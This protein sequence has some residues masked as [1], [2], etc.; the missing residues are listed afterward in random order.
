VA[1]LSRVAA[2]APADERVRL[3]LAIA[4][5]GAGQLEDAQKDYQELLKITTKPKNALFGLG[6]IAWRRQQTNE[7]I[8]LYQQYLSAGIP[9]SPQYAVVSERLRQLKGL[10]PTNAVAR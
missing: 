6:S 10:A 9:G 8:E 4:R 1:T 5:L 2:R 7:A 3:S